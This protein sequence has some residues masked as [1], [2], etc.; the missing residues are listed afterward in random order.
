RVQ[1]VH[2]DEL[3]GHVDAG[4]LRELGGL[5]LHLDVRGRNEADPLEDLGLGALRK[6]GRFLRL[7]DARDAAGGDCPRCRAG[8]LQEGSPTYTR[9]VAPLHGSLP[10]CPIGRFN[11]CRP[12]SR[13]R[14][15]LTRA[16]TTGPKPA[17]ARNVAPSDTPGPGGS[18][19]AP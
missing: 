8:R 14:A 7:E 13:S 15:P 3:D 5:S 9:P 17:L 1:V 6:A 18:S 19:V 11:A 12:M 16:D 4:E 10:G 2:V